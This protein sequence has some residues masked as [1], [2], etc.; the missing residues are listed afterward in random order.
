MSVMIISD[1]HLESADDPK[2]A[3]FDRCID[4]VA[5]TAN[6]LLILGDLF[7][8]WVGDDDDGPLAARVASTLRALADAGIEIG[9]QQGNRDFLVGEDYARRCGMRVLPEVATIW[10]GGTLVLVAHGDSL[11]TDDLAY[12]TVRRQFRDPAWQHDF[13]QRPLS[14]RR[15]FAEQARVASRAHAAGAG[16][17]I[18]DIVPMEAFKLLREHRALMLVHGHTHRPAI[19]HDMLDGTPVQRVVTSDWLDDRGEILRIDELAPHKVGAT[20]I[21]IAAE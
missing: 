9:F 8:A 19:H 2:L 15:A 17:S 12:Q 1:L 13:L 5:R 7:E 14:E 4:V 6:R 21:V 10:I 16:S 11:C 20:R 3:L 18:G